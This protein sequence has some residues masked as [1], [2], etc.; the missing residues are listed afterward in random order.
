MKPMIAIASPLT[1]CR[2]LAIDSRMMLPTEG[3][4]S[5]PNSR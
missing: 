4:Q 5:S 1:I 2:S 3:P